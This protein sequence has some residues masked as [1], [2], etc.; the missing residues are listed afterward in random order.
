MPLVSPL[1][2]DG[3][4]ESKLDEYILPRVFFTKVVNS[5]SFSSGILLGVLLNLQ[6]RFKVS[7]SLMTW[8]VEKRA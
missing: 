1:D 7:M 8:S 6:V 5:F 2:E 3:D 4:E